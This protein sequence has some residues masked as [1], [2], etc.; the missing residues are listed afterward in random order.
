[1]AWTKE[2]I[3]VRVRDKNSDV[4]RALIGERF[5]RIDLVEGPVDG[6]AGNSLNVLISF[7]PLED[8]PL[9]AYDWVHSAGAGVDHLCEA[10]PDPETAPIITRTVGRMGE[11][12]GEYCVGYGL[13]HL[14][15]M[16]D[17]RAAQAA[18]LWDKAGAEP[19]YMFD[20]HVVIFGTGG[21]GSGVARAFRA[22]GAKVT[23]VSRTGAAHAD[24]DEVVAFGNLAEPDKADIVVL[25]LPA[26]PQTAGLV[27][28]DV[29]ERLDNAL[30]IN[31]GRGSTLDPAALRQALAKGHV[32]HAVLDVFE[33][34]PLPEGD[35]RWGDPRVTVTPHVSGLTRPQDAAERFCEL[36]ADYLATGTRPRS[37]DVRRGY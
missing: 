5:P 15:Q 27:G 35:W 6:A 36:L 24:F 4:M 17:R 32:A 7:R 26:T 14:Q 20:S 21:I 10:I 16:A 30:L 1:M 23:G 37:V 33:T 28:G 19:R 11:Q 9:S 29:L 34:E 8:E 2:K 25:A 31:V 12:I 22:L 13:A 3:V 18:G